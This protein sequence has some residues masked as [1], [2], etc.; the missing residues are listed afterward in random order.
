LKSSQEESG[1]EDDMID[2]DM[3]GHVAPLLPSSLDHEKV[4]NIEE[5]ESADEDELLVPFR[6]NNEVNLFVEDQLHKV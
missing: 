1:H 5:E 3:E 6:D 2:F 4:T